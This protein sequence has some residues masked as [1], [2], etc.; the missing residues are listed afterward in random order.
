VDVKGTCTPPLQPLRHLPAFAAA[1]VGLAW[2]VYPHTLYDCIFTHRICGGVP[3][4]NTVYNIYRV[5]ANLRHIVCGVY[6]LQDLDVISSVRQSLGQ[7]AP[8]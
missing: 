4:K 5:L 6:W 2:T 3:A 7:N 1:C 8:S